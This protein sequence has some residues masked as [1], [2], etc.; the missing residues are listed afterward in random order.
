MKKYLIIYES[1]RQEI[2]EAEDFDDIYRKIDGDII[3]VIRL[4]SDLK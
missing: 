2:L 4:N 1:G 3:V